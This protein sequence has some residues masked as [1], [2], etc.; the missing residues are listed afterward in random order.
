ML[1]VVASLLWLCLSEAPALAY[2]NPVFAVVLDSLDVVEEY[3][4]TAALDYAPG[5]LDVLDAASPPPLSFFKTLPLI[6]FGLTWAVYALT[7][8]KPGCRPR[9]YIGKS[10]NST[11]GALTRMADYDNKRSL[12]EYIKKSLDDGFTI[13]HKGYL[14]IK[15]NPAPSKFPVIE[16]VILALEATFAFFFWA[17]HSRVKDYNMSHARGWN[18]DAYEYDGACSHNPM[19]EGLIWT[20]LTPE[21]A[22]T[23]AAESKQRKR[24]E[25]IRKEAKA[26]RSKRFHCKTCN[27]SF[28]TRTKLERHNAV[29]YH[30]NRLNGP[31]I[32]KTPQAKY[33]AKCV[34]T[35]KHYC[36]LCNYPAPTNHGLQKHY[37]TD[38]HKFAVVAAQKAAAEAALSS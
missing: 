30:K 22:T 6:T 3:L 8:E 38:K 21:Q 33:Q 28:S 9:I 32:T 25:N 18:L 26:K 19:M 4:Q 17:M 24:D 37:G 7:L 11:R 2:F 14:C 16:A 34:R 23:L 31:K 12:P 5:L 35:K 15:R 29:P 10:T 36:A 1:E 27:R 13:T 20:E